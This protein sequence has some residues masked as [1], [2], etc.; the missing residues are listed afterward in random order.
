[1]SNRKLLAVLCL[2]ALSAVALPT[3]AVADFDGPAIERLQPDTDWLD[4]IVQ[5]FQK[6][7]GMLESPFV[8]Q[9]GSAIGQDG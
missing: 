8:A 7:M 9:E 1:M 2:V 6:V 3:G 5:L 4:R